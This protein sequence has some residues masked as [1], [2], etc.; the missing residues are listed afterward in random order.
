MV[1]G[2][3]LYGTVFFAKFQDALESLKQKDKISVEVETDHHIKVS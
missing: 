2:G 1:T 3:F